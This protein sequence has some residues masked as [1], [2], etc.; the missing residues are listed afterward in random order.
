MTKKRRLKILYKKLDKV[1]AAIDSRPATEAELKRCRQ[2]EREI[3]WRKP[4]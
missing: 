4:R 3:N 2:L 1:F